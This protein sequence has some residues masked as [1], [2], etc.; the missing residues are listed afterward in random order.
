MAGGLP[1]QKGCG[2]AL[3][4]RTSTSLHPFT[5]TIELGTCSRSP[6]AFATNLGFFFKHRGT[7]EA[8]SVDI[9]HPFRTAV[10]L[11]S[12]GWFAIGVLI[13]TGAWGFTSRR[14]R[15]RRCRQCRSYWPAASS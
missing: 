3:R 6:A 14:S 10:Q 7:N 8:P 12:S 5:V 9:R 15:W 13:A 1:I 11:Y 4:N 2:F